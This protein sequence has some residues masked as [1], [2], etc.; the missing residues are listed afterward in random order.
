MKVYLQTVI[1][2]SDLRIKQ[3]ISLQNNDKATPGSTN[4]F[5]PRLP[6]ASYVQIWTCPCKISSYRNQTLNKTTIYIYIYISGFS[7]M[8]NDSAGRRVIMSRK[9]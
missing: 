4:L 5:F 1:R 3:L 2:P 9:L 6:R 8:V 7:T